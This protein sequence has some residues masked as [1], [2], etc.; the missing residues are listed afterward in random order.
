MATKKPSPAQLRARAAFVKMVKERARLR[1][2]GKLAPVKRKTKA[3]KVRRVAGKPSPAQLAARA[4]FAAMSRAKAKGKKAAK[5]KKNPGIIKMSEAEFS[6]FSSK[7]KGVGSAPKITRTRSASPSKRKAGKRFKKVGVFGGGGFLGLGKSIQT[8]KRN[9][10]LVAKIKKLIAGSGKKKKVAKVGTRRTQRGR[11]TAA[12]VG[13]RRTQRGRKLNPAPANVFSE[14]RGKDVTRRTKVKAASGT[15]STLA[16]LGKLRELR[17]RGKTLKF[18]AGHL[19]A[20]GRKKLHVVGV[21]AK[22]RGNP[23]EV[24]YGEI[25]SVTYEADKPHVEEG[26]FNYIHRFGED[27]GTRPHLVVDPE[28]FMK[29]EGG[30]YKI[31]AD[32]IID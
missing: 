29:I 15:P 1:A 24:D 28:G 20:D 26:V 31:S 23:G 13:Y 25:I 8:I 14:F 21:K 3:A 18:R 12:P 10:G 11:H 32:G 19:A 2:A 4:K 30:S 27:G 7:I 22:H 9:P 17:L 16:Q 5:G 6:K